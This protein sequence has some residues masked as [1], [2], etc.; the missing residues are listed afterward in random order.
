MRILLVEDERGLALAI[1]EHLVAQTHAV[2]HVAT[3]EDAK[4]ALRAVN[5][6]LLLLDLSLPDGNG[7]DL[8]KLPHT[9]KRNLP[10]IILT[11]RDQI[12]DRIAGLDAGADD[13]LV[14]PFDLDELLS[15]IAAVMRRVIVHNISE[16]TVADITI[17]LQ[18]R[19]VA[20]KGR[21]IAL[22]AREWSIL[23]CLL[24]RKGHIVPRSE[25]EDAIYG[26]GEEIDS[27]AI[28]AHIS[29][30]RK[31]LG[32]PIIQNTRGIGYRIK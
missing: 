24:L 31:K 8:V 5:Y 17:S 6:D 26:F 13:Y 25:I 19:H 9:N 27:N 29:R 12:S 30:L 1:C 28:E 4:A 15:R 14:K 32:T 2:D 3:L 7:I 23:E 21:E 22:S 16:I 20:N 10:I 18:R 11:A